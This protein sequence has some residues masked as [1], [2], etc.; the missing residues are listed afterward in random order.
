MADARASCVR[1]LL[2]QLIKYTEQLARCE[3]DPGV[4]VGV[5]ADACYQR[6]A[7]LQ[8]LTREGLPADCRAEERAA[9]EHP[10]IRELMRT[11]RN[12]TRGCL[13]A[14]ERSRDR[15]GK[16]LDSDRQVRRAIQA[17]R[18]K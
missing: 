6:L 5:L 15:I 7:M 18:G 3:D 13:G 10:T 4:D 16:E 2:I 11:L 1:A 14:M 17:Y 8:V 9:E 12:R